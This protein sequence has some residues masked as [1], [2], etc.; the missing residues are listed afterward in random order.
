MYK[1]KLHRGTIEAVNHWELLKK[2]Y[3]ML[4][5]SKGGTGEADFRGIYDVINCIVCLFY[6]L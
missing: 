1:D 3:Q 5:K 4:P 2:G 6:L